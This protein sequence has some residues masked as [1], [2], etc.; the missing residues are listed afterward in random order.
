MTHTHKRET[1]QGGHVVGE[2]GK[3]KGSLEIGVVG[4]VRC[5]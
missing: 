4:G 5:V 3:G 2:G 1:L